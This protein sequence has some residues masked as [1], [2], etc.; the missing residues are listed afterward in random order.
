MAK[1]SWRRRTPGVSCMC[2]GGGQIGEAAFMARPLGNT[3]AKKAR[4]SG[5]RRDMARKGICT[6]VA[7]GGNDL[8][9]SIWW[10]A[11]HRIRKK[12]Q[13]KPLAKPGTWHWQSPGQLPIVGKRACVSRSHWLSLAASTSGLLITC[14]VC[15]LDVELL[16]VSNSGGRKSEAAFGPPQLEGFAS[17]RRAPD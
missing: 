9:R 10:V 14:V 17:R 7:S 2:R 11:L 13:A 3:A 5:S 16:T 1:P 6:R 12:S 4:H 15:L 8:R